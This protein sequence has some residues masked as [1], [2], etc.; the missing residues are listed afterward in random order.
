VIRDAYPFR[1]CLSRSCAN[2]D[3]LQPRMGASR[4]RAVWL[5]PDSRFGHSILTRVHSTVHMRYPCGTSLAP[6]PPSCWQSPCTPSRDKHAT[7]VGDVVGWASHR[8]VTSPAC[9][10]RL[11]LVVQRVTVMTGVMRDKAIQDIAALRRISPASGGRCTHI[12]CGDCA[13]KT[14][15]RSTSDNPE[16]FRHGARLNNFGRFSAGPF[17]PG[18]AGEA[19]LL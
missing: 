6:H 8:T 9:H 12:T 11:S 3:V 13:C 4:Q 15:S 5:W 1:G 18:S 16:A 19:D 17:I 14:S 7:N 10:R 2:S